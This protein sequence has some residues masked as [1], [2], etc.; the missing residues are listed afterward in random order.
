VRLFV[1]IKIEEK[2]VKELSKIQEELKKRSKGVRWVKKENLHLTLKFLGE[3]EGNKI[4]EVEEEI[5][6][7][8]IG[9]KRFELSFERI[10]YFPNE[11]RPKIVWIGI[12]E[13]RDNFIKIAERLN[14]RLNKFRKEER[15][16]IPHL[17]LGRLKYGGEVVVNDQNFKTS[18]F[19]VTKVYLI[20][21]KLLETG[22]LYTVIKEFSLS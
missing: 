7:G 16:I 21:S 15:K 19:W 12:E 2:V 17:T 18:S 4:G 22:P 3:I 10:G 5:K 6:K 11:R 8:I 1:G 13:G 20:K 9:E 14:K